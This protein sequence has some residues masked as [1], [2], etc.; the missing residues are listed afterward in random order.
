M[1]IFAVGARANWTLRA[2]AKT[3]EEVN[4]TLCETRGVRLPRM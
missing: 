3:L 1:H 2:S 4:R